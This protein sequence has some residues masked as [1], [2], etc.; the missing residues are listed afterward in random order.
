VVLVEHRLIAVPLEDCRG[1][2]NRFASTPSVVRLGCKSVV[3]ATSARIST[4]TGPR[5][6]IE[7]C[8]TVA[9]AISATLAAPAS[10]GRWEVRLHA[11]HPAEEFHIVARAIVTAR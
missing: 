9:G 4:S 11:R 7:R 1:I 3:P 10:S 5:S 2:A 8:T 6:S